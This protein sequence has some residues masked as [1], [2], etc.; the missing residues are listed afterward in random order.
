MPCV[1]SLRF[2]PDVMAPLNCYSTT[3]PQPFPPTRHPH[4]LLQVT[5]KMMIGSCVLLVFT[6][7]F[8]SQ[9]PFFIFFLVTFRG[10]FPHSCPL[11]TG[12]QQ[13]GQCWVQLEREKPLAFD[14]ISCLFVPLQPSSLKMVIL[15][16]FSSPTSEYSFSMVWSDSGQ[17]GDT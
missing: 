12:R 7:P 8:P 1:T 14:L 6:A 10:V 4:H 17:G 16:F 11:R 2:E 13:I 5:K 9:P 3:P 15:V